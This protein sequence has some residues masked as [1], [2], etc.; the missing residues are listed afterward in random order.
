MKHKRF[1]LIMAVM[2]VFSLFGAALPAVAQTNGDG[3]TW[4]EMDS[5]TTKA[6]SGIWGSSSS[7]VFAVGSDGTILLYDGSTW[8]STPNSTLT[9]EFFRP[10]IKSRETY[11]YYGISA[12]WC[13]SSSD[14]FAVGTLTVSK[15]PLPGEFPPP[16]GFPS[17]DEFPPLSQ[18]PQS[19]FL[20]YDGSN[21]NMMERIISSRFL[22]G[23]WGNSPSDVFV[24]GSDLGV[25]HYDGNSWSSM[26]DIEFEDAEEKFIF[27]HKFLSAVWG[28]SSSDVFAVGSDGIIVHYDGSTWKKMYANNMRYFT[29]VWGSS[30]SDVFVVGSDGFILH[31]DG[32][33]WERMNSGTT[34]NLRDIWGSSSSDVFA[35]GSDGT[36]LH[37][38]GSVWEEMNSGTTKT[39]HSVW[40]SSSSN[41]FAVGSGGTI[42]HY[43]NPRVTAVSIGSGD[44]G[45]TLDAIITGAYFT[46]A[47][48][49]SFGAGVTVNSFT[50]D[51]STQI[52]ASISIA[53]DAT[54]GARDVLVTTPA[55]TETLA[56]GFIVKVPLPTVTGIN[57]ASGDQG[58]TLDIVITGAHF[59][60]ATE[61]SFGAGVTVNSFILDSSTQITASISIAA[62]A[63]IRARDVLVTTPA[64]T[65]TLAGGFIVEQAVPEPTEPEPAAEPAPTPTPVE[66]LPVQPP[67]NWWL[68]GGIIAAGCVVAG[69]LGY[70]FVWQKHGATRPS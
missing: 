2:L 42:L 25:W 31:Y 68:I 35:V 64:G 39:L 4:E 3:G 1:A 12:V 15:N 6:L 63:A 58:V 49:I 46:G 66:P 51:S 5:G 60:G 30:S 13:S 47:T 48:A 11:L 36:I 65:G 28:S 33:V 38:D 17:P 55:G 50:L 34:E 57:I 52:T 26:P 67:T 62:D 19:L 18:L 9:E 54:I 24:V 27:W 16:D 45:T 61:V 10:I 70:F 69:L 41:V 43:G 44:Q 29:G 22:S 8:N 53:A 32:S 23:V 40:G 56:D 14:I 37:Y 20:H 21:W 7:D 59:T